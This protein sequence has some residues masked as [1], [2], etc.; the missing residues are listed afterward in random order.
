[1]ELVADWP[2]SGAGHYELQ[3]ELDGNL[4]EAS[5]WTVNP[6]KLSSVAFRHLLDD[7]ESRLPVTVALAL[8][9]LGAATG[10]RLAQPTGVSSPAEEL[11]RLRRA[12]S[13]TSA[14]PGLALILREIAQDP[15]QVLTD[16][17]VWVPA[18]RARRVSATGLVR[19]V[20]LG[21]N[22]TSPGAP[23]RLP[24]N[25]VEAT[26]DVYENRLLRAFVDQVELRLRRLRSYLAARN[27]ASSTDEL[28]AL[29]R[30]L[31]AARSQ[32]S[33]LREVGR[34]GQ[35]PTSVTM[36]LVKKP[37]YRKLL[38]AFLEFQRRTVVRLNE[39]ALES[40][41]ENL[42]SL[43]E[44]WGVLQAID[45]I[46]ELGAE[47][48]YHMAQ[49]EVF[50]HGPVGAWIEV[51]PNG[52]P[53]V[54]LE[55]SSDD[56]TISVIPQRTYATDGSGLKS[57]SYPQK[58][59]LAIEVARA[60]QPTEVY[61]LDPKYRLESEMS[62]HGPTDGKPK[63]VDIDKMH[64]YRDAIRDADGRR[65]VKFAG[66][67]YPGTQQQF[68]P[69]LAALSAVPGANAALAGELRRALAPAFV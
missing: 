46:L 36:V 43:Y 31:S 62:P 40:P 39:P 20:A 22:A 11:A 14:G 60:Q 5:R 58:P 56:T 45:A 33:F 50:R 37:A 65:V 34:L 30:K 48:G 17:E 1:M 18:E 57:I 25:R 47:H 53:A 63:K 10:N 7:L 8:Q 23:D 19:A 54:K 59:D 38:E 12:I 27:S 66:I 13:R 35:A 16:V 9:K 51:L 69:G 41:L 68:T 15:H 28:D 3:L 42:P 61:L 21:S 67:L 6:A 24:D 26:V 2:L 32:A 49:S 29:E 44:T 55:R 52:R 4:V 64:A